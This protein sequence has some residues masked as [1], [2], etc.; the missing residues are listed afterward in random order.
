MTVKIINSHFFHVFKWVYSRLEPLRKRQFCILFGGMIFV[1]IIETI[2]LGSIAFFA[3]AVTDPSN[4]LSSKYVVYLRQFF[5]F[6]FLRSAKGLIIVSGSLMCTLILLKN[7]LKAIVNYGVS[8][9]SVIEEAY[10]GNILLNGFLRMPYQWHLDKNSAD[11]INAV[12]WR[13]YLGRRFFQPSLIIFNNLIM[14]TIIM[15]TLFIVQPILSFS[16]IIV[17]GSSALIIYKVIRIRIDKAARRARDYQITINKEATM[18]I[19]GIK[20]VKICGHEKIFV[21]KFDSNAIPLSKILGIQRIYGDSPV[22]ILEVVGFG[23]LYLAICIMLLKLDVTTA[24]V[25]GMM[26]LLSVTAWKTLPAVSQILN[27][28]SKIRGALPY[29]QTIMDFILI[30]ETQSKTQTTDTPIFFSRSIEFK[31]VSFSYHESSPEIL[32]EISFNIKKGETIGIIGTSG[33]GKSTLVDL[34]IGLLKPVKGKI[35]IDGKELTNE[36][37]PAWLEITGYVPQSSYIYDGTFTEN[38]AFGVA[39]EK[40]D[41]KRVE[42]CCIM[43]S[44]DKVVE[45]LPDGIDAL[46]GERGVKLSGGQQQ[47]VAI[48]RALYRNPELIIFDEATSSLDT[49]SEQAIQKT[50]YSFKGKQTLII[51]AHRLSTIRDCDKVLWINDGRIEIYDSPD[52]V[53]KAYNDYN[54]L[55]E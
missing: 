50:I 38:I 25:I 30:I 28:F 45:N 34:L 41:R 24:Y 44:M 33:A 46:I 48:A 2:T 9:F 20:D 40:I 5:Q 26:A 21:A 39:N 36:T 37:I 51:I 55:K 52:K 1:A 10:F 3:S 53:I 54:P 19:Q 49:K 8:R 13:T 47:R 32:K 12:A 35:C 14:L 43:A 42:Q 22:L 31:T 17:L 11:L 29:I 23:V 6:D 18:A 15:S 16:T 7:S 27:S 4:V